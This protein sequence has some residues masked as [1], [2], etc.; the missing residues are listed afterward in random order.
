MVSGYLRDVCRRRG[1]PRQW[2]RGRR[3]RRR[4]RRVR[5]D[6]RRSRTWEGCAAGYTCDSRHARFS[7][8]SVVLACVDP[9]ANAGQ[10]R[11]FL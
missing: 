7:V 6:R 3:H 9:G 11:T 5:P 2:R 4:R 8:D 10:S 1:S